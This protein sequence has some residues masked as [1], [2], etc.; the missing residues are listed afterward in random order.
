MKKIAITKIENDQNEVGVQLRDSAPVTQKEGRIYIDRQTGEMKGFINNQDVHLS[1]DVY[2]SDPSLPVE[3]QAW[4]NTG[5]NKLKWKFNGVVQSISLD[6]SLKLQD[7]QSTNFYLSTLNE[8]E[9]GNIADVSTE[10]PNYLLDAFNG[11]TEG[12]IYTN[13][14]MAQSGIK[15][16]DGETSGE[17]ELE[18]KGTAGFNYAEGAVVMKSNAFRPKSISDNND[19]THE[20]VFTGNLTDKLEVNKNILMLQKEDDMELYLIKGDLNPAILNIS[21]VSYSVGDDETTVQVD[22]QEL[23]LTFG[24]ASVEDINIKPMNFKLYAGADG[25]SGNLSELKI[26]EA[27]SIDSLSSVLGDDNLR[28]LTLGWD[29]EK[30]Y[31]VVTQHSPNRQN[32]IVGV[33][34]VSGENIGRVSGTVFLWK[35]TDGFQTLE[36]VNNFFH[37]TTFPTDD[38]NLGWSNYA[39]FGD[40]KTFRD[41]NFAIN[42]D[43][44]YV[45]A[46]PMYTPADTYSH[47]GFFGD[48]NDN[49]IPSRM[50]DTRSSTYPGHLGMDN[51]NSYYGADIAECIDW[52]ENI[53]FQ[54]TYN[55][56]DDPYTIPMRID[57]ANRRTDSHGYF[58]LGSNYQY[59]AYVPLVFMKEFEGEKQFFV[60]SNNTN[61]NLYAH[62]FRYKRYFDDIDAGLQPSYLAGSEANIASAS[63]PV[64]G[65]AYILN[66]FSN[67]LEGGTRGETNAFVHSQFHTNRR[68]VDY[69]WDE[70]SDSLVILHSDVSQYILTLTVTNFGRTRYGKTNNTRLEF[71]NVPDAG[72]FTLSIFDEDTGTT[73][74]TSPFAFSNTA[75][76]LQSII[77]SLSFVGAGNCT[78]TGDFSSGFDISFGVQYMRKELNI[79]VNTQSI[80]QGGTA[81]QITVNEIEAGEKPIWLRHTA[82]SPIGTGDNSD[83]NGWDVFLDDYM[84]VEQS[85]AK[86]GTNANSA[87]IAVNRGQVMSVKNKT[88]QFLLETVDTEDAHDAAITTYFKIPDYTQFVGQGDTSIRHS[89]PVDGNGSRAYYAGT[90]HIFRI[91]HAHRHGD[92]RTGTRIAQMWNTG[93]DTNGIYPD[94]KIPLRTMQIRMSSYY[95]GIDSKFTTW[96]NPDIKMKIRI[97]LPDGEGKPDYDNPIAISKPRMARNFSNTNDD[98]WEQFI[99]DDVRLDQN[100]DYYFVLETEGIDLGKLPLTNE[101]YGG[102]NLQGASVTNV[103]K[104]WVY[105]NYQDDD[106]RWESQSSAIWFK[107]YDYY[108]TKV[109]T[110]HES[111]ENVDVRTF[112]PEWYDGRQISDST[113][114]EKPDTPDVFLSTYRN[115]GRNLNNYTSYHRIHGGSHAYQFYIEDTNG[116]YAFPTVKDPVILGG[117]DD[118]W[119]RHLVFAHIP[120]LDSYKQ[121][122]IN[123]DGSP[124]KLGT[125]E[126]DYNYN[127]SAMFGGYQVSQDVSLQRRKE[128]SG[129]ANGI[130]DDNRFRYGVCVHP[131]GQGRIYYY[132]SPTAVA[133]F[134]HEFIF[135]Y[136]WDIEQQDIDSSISGNER[137]SFSV[138]N[139]WYTGL[140]RGKHS[141]FGNVNGTGRR[142]MSDFPVVTGYQRLRVTRDRVKGIRLWRNFSKS[143]G[144]WE[145]LDTSSGNNQTLNAESGEWFNEGAMIGGST[146]TDTTYWS[147]GGYFS[148]SSHHC[149]GRI[150]YVKMAI[151]SSEFKYDGVNENQKELHYIKNY[152]DKL[153]ALQ[154]FNVGYNPI[155]H[156]AMD[157]AVIIKPDSGD[158]AIV[159]SKHTALRVKGSVEA[160]RDLA[161]KL[162]LEKVSDSD[163]SGLE[164]FAVSYSKK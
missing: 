160:G 17:Y 122:R 22:D 161:I 159:E 47:R 124:E 99:F 163:Q 50:T 128:Y 77:E 116:K 70:E 63:S 97:C 112:V 144:V 155:Y 41:A 88:I 98:K 136:E 101:S 59:T 51:G 87:S 95:F 11:N 83:E 139:S 64:D 66:A 86:G 20:L 126:N 36:F 84:V 54:F 1:F 109:H 127:G 94:G 103:Q 104:C 19:G 10:F 37:Y 80:N 142:V 6:N 62:K 35:S 90:E 152:G 14:E 158:S 26:T 21:A 55:G 137:I 58:L 75:S 29:D 102:L 123:Q 45:I 140:A 115:H 43:G 31:H 131:N 114:V 4:V 147:Y 111:G 68:M 81:T 118:W 129:N 44:R 105:R 78:V 162:D 145:E 71:D 56:A 69:G 130:E 53:I 148:G 38:Q 32:W 134:Q 107:W 132:Y 93:N 120:G 65:D 110:A 119:D 133:P 9:L 150:G 8:E 89:S 42:D 33:M 48:L 7:N 146:I 96:E 141:F 49:E 12:A 143:G 85:Y 153:T 67:S 16:V 40:L 34:V 157:K 91:A 156:R 15:V 113:F 60:I 23:D 27:N 138:P 121:L 151:G 72:N 82:K 92:S 76:Q 28:K 25:L 100:K 73:E 149:Y 125:D 154:A 79:T 30:V 5:E 52:D 13:T 2:E 164:G 108:Q 74:I 18:K 3:K 24:G 57:W 46:L 39:S 61:E 106:Y 135:E 117:M